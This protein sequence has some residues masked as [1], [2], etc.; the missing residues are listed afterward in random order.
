MGAACSTSSTAGGRVESTTHPSHQCQAHSHRSAQQLSSSSSP[1]P[2]SPLARLH[3]FLPSSPFPLLN[4]VVRLPRG[5]IRV[6]PALSHSS[7]PSNAV[8]ALPST[9]HPHLYVSVLTPSDSLCDLICRSPTTSFAFFLLAPQ[10]PAPLPSSPLTLQLHVA[11]H[12]LP[13]HHPD[14]CYATPFTSTRQMS[15]TW[16][17]SAATG[18]TVTLTP[19]SDAGRRGEAGD[20]AFP[21]HLYTARMSDKQY[22]RFERLTFTFL[23]RLRTFLLDATRHPAFTSVDAGHRHSMDCSPLHL[24]AFT[25]IQ[26]SGLRLTF[27]GLS[28]GPFHADIDWKGEQPR[29]LC[30]ELGPLIDAASADHSLSCFISRAWTTARGAIGLDDWRRLSLDIFSLSPPPPFLTSSIAAKGSTLR[31]AASPACCP[32]P[33]P[34][35]PSLA[36]SIGVDPSDPSSLMHSRDGSTRATFDRRFLRSYLREYAVQYAGTT[37]LDVVVTNLNPQTLLTPKRASTLAPPALASP[38]GKEESDERR[39]KQSVLEMLGKVM[40]AI[41]AILALEEEAPRVPQWAIDVTDALLHVLCL[42]STHHKLVHTGLAILRRFALHESCHQPLQRMLNQHLAHHPL[43]QGCLLALF[44]LLQSS[45]AFARSIQFSST[46]SRLLSIHSLASFTMLPESASLAPPPLPSLPALPPVDAH[47]PSHRSPSASHA[48]ATR[49]SSSPGS[50]SQPLQATSPPPLHPRQPRLSAMSFSARPPPS[51]LSSPLLLSPLR[52]RSSSAQP[53]S[54]AV[55]LPSLGSGVALAQTPTGAATMRSVSFLRSALSAAAHRDEDE[56]RQTSARVDMDAEL[57]AESAGSGSSSGV[58]S[59]LKASPGLQLR[60][61]S[62]P[63]ERKEADDADTTNSSSHTPTDSP[64]SASPLPTLRPHKSKHR[65]VHRSDYEEEEKVDH[66]SAVSSSP[67]VVIPKLKLSLAFIP[68]STASVVPAPLSSMR[69][70]RRMSRVATTRLGQMR[71]DAAFSYQGLMS[72]SATMTGFSIPAAMASPTSRVLG[73]HR[74]SILDPP[75]PSTFSL[76]SQGG[77]WLSTEAEGRAALRRLKDI[78]VSAGECFVTSQLA[79]LLWCHMQQQ[80]QQQHQQQQHDLATARL[81]VGGEEGGGWRRK[82]T[83]SLSSMAPQLTQRS[84]AEVSPSTAQGSATPSDLSLFYCAVLSLRCVLLLTTATST[85]RQSADAEGA[86]AS[87]FSALT[88]SRHLQRLKESGE[89]AGS[90]AVRLSF[91]HLRFYEQ[92]LCHA[93]RQCSSSPDPLRLSSTSPSLSSAPSSTSCLWWL[94]SRSGQSMPLLTTSGLTLA[95]S[96]PFAFGPTVCLLPTSLLSPINRASTAAYADIPMD[97]TTSSVSAP[98]LALHVT[99]EESSVAPPPIDGLVAARTADS[100]LRRRAAEL[101][102]VVEQLALLQPSTPYQHAVQLLQATTAALHSLHRYAIHSSCHQGLRSAFA[103]SSSHCLHPTLASSSSSDVSCECGNSIALLL[104]TCGPSLLDGHAQLSRI[105]RLCKEQAAAAAAQP[106][107]VWSPVARLPPVP[108]SSPP[109]EVER[110]TAVNALVSL[111]VSLLSHPSSHSTQSLLLRLLRDPTALPEGSSHQLPRWEKGEGEGKGPA[112]GARK[113]AQSDA[114]AALF[115]VLDFVHNH[116]L[117]VYASSASSYCL[118]VA[119]AATGG[120]RNVTVDAV[121]NSQRASLASTRMQRSSK[122]GSSG[123]MTGSGRDL[124]STAPSSAHSTAAAASAEEEEEVNAVPVP[125]YPVVHAARLYVL[126]FYRAVAWLL[127]RVGEST[128]EEL[129]D[130]RA[131]EEEL[132]PVGWPRPTIGDA[133]ARRS[134]RRAPI[135]EEEEEDDEDSDAPEPSHGDGNQRDD[136]EGANDLELTARERRQARRS[137]QARSRHSTMSGAP[138]ALGLSAEAKAERFE[139]YWSSV[140]ELIASPHALIARL[141]QLQ[142]TADGSRGGGDAG[143]EADSDSDGDDEEQTTEASTSRSSSSLSSMS[144]DADRSTPRRPSTRQA[145]Q[146][147]AEFDLLS[148]YSGLWGDLLGWKEAECPFL[149]DEKLMDSL[150]RLHFIAFIR[151]YHAQQGLDP[152]RADTCTLH[153]HILIAIST[154]TS[155]LLTSP[156]TAS[157]AVPLSRAR[158][159]SSRADLAG[160]EDPSDSAASPR[161]SE[162]PHRAVVDGICEAFHRLRVVHFLSKELN[163]EHDTFVARS[164]L[165]AAAGGGGPVTAGNTTA[166]NTTAVNTARGVGTVFSPQMSRSLSMLS[167]FDA[168][169]VPSSP[170]PALHQLTVAAA[171]DA[172]VTKRAEDVNSHPPSADPLPVTRVDAALQPAPASGEHRRS[173]SSPVSAP[174]PL[175]LPLNP[176]SFPSLDSSSGQLASPL[177]T[178][179]EEEDDDGESDEASPAAA[180][181]HSLTPKQG[182][183]REDEEDVEEDEAELSSAAEGSLASLQEETALRREHADGGDGDFDELTSEVTSAQ[184]SRLLATA[185]NRPSLTRPSTKSGRRRTF[186]SSDGAH[187]AQEGDTHG[188]EGVGDDDDEEL[189]EYEASDLS[190]SMKRPSPLDQLNLALP[191]SA[192]PAEEE[193][194][195][196]GADTAEHSHIGDDDDDGYEASETSSV[197]PSRAEGGDPPATQRPRFQLNIAPAQSVSAGT[198]GASPAEDADQEEEGDGDATEEESDLVNGWSDSESLHDA[199]TARRDGGAGLKLQLIVPSSSVSADPSPT[200]SSPS[201]SLAVKG[202]DGSVNASPAQLPS[203]RMPLRLP[204]SSDRTPELS[205]S[206]VPSNS[207]SSVESTLASLP[208]HRLPTLALKVEHSPEHAASPQSTDSSATAS[209]GA[210][211]P[212]LPAFSRVARH[213]PSLSLHLPAAAAARPPLSPSPLSTTQEVAI[214]DPTLPGV[215]DQPLHGDTPI[216]ATLPS[217][218]P[219]PL[220]AIGAVRGSFALAPPLKLQC[221]SSSSSSS[222]PTQQLSPGDEGRSVP[223]VSFSS[224]GSGPSSGRRSVRGKSFGVKVSS[225]VDVYAKLRQQRRLYN[226]PSLHAAMLRLL[227]RLL[228]DPSDSAL[229]S[230]YCDRALT[231]ANS[232]AD[233]DVDV[234]TSLHSHLNHPSNSTILSALFATSLTPHSSPLTRLLKLLCEPLFPT[235]LFLHP[236]STQIGRGQFAQVYLAHLPCLP[237]PLAVKQIDMASTAHQRVVLFDLFTEVSVMERMR[238]HKGVVGLV[239]YGV[240]RGQYYLVMKAMSKSLRAWREEVGKGKWGGGGAGQRGKR[241]ASREVVSPCFTE[242]QLMLYLYL[243][244]RVLHALRALHAAGV[245]HFDLKLDNV[246]IDL[247]SPSDPSSWSVAIADFGESLSVLHGGGSLISRGTENVQSPEMLLLT[248]VL[249]AGHHAFDRRR[250]HT[251]DAASDVWSLG[252]LFYEL[253]TN[254][255]LFEASDGLPIVLR[256]TSQ[257]GS[258]L[259][260]KERGMLGTWGGRPNRALMK[261]LCGVLVHNKDR[262]PTL[263]K[264]EGMFEAMVKELFPRGL[265]VTGRGEGLMSPVL[266]GPVGVGRQWMDGAHKREKHQPRSLSVQIDMQS[267]APPPFLPLASSK[268]GVVDRL[269]GGG[270]GAEAAAASPRAASALAKPMKMGRLLSSRRLSILPS[271]PPLALHYTPVSEDLQL[272]IHA[273]LSSLCVG[274]RHGKAT[275]VTPAD[276]FSTSPWPC[277]HF[278]QVRIAKPGAG[279]SRPDVTALSIPSLTFHGWHREGGQAPTAGSLPS[280]APSWSDEPLLLSSAPQEV[281]EVVE[282]MRDAIALG[283]RALLFVDADEVGV[284]ADDQL[285]SLRGLCCAYVMAVYGVPWLEAACMVHEKLPISAP[286]VDGATRL[287]SALSSASEPERPSVGAAPAARHHRESLF[288][289]SVIVQQATAADGR[290]RSTGLVVS[291][292]SAPFAY[293]S[294]WPLRVAPALLKWMAASTLHVNP[295][296]PLSYKRF[297]ASLSSASPSPTALVTHRCLCGFCLLTCSIASPIRRCRC[298]PSLSTSPLPSSPFTQ[299]PTAPLGCRWFEARTK[300]LYGRGGALQWKALQPPSP[301][302]APTPAFPASSRSTA[303]TSPPTPSQWSPAVPFAVLTALRSVPYLSHSSSSGWHLYECKH[304]L[305]PFL[306]VLPSTPSS[307]SAS[308]SH[309]PAAG[310]VRCDGLEVMGLQV[311][312]GM[313]VGRDDRVQG[314]SSSLDDDAHYQLDRRPR[315]FFS[316]IA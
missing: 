270:S 100:W 96:R 24:S 291:K 138:V 73:T 83:V 222:S 128:R 311:L 181:P 34:P 217:F 56:K 103:T 81:G 32:S 174:Q 272:P 66:A 12:Y 136:E 225:A 164:Y 312:A 156:L 84:M 211:L 62:A 75:A 206:V 121:F 254:R 252:C 304:C 127:Q 207:S 278:I 119:T 240:S 51:T 243:F 125:Q 192:A 25:D 245:V 237:Q 236:S 67:A 280:T 134:S 142:V 120:P 175:M 241:W 33:H 16:V 160:E 133:T 249:D 180:S 132:D 155:T 267:S 68:Q 115:S 307:S 255:F 140:G 28:H 310:C 151:N 77:Q 315:A 208:S 300:N 301:T 198:S 171:V 7:N 90:A 124:Y 131:S 275:A 287:T 186:D 259:S 309:D 45:P 122:A 248:Q 43:C 185:S 173:A 98:A 242:S 61:T 13:R 149:L 306:A 112:R 258:L 21:A 279:I 110:L 2:R 70:S 17:H 313:R 210:A 57:T 79:T 316:R 261:F 197:R 97:S 53:A 20:G 14:A 126:D 6:D 268:L 144:S 123:A 35:V 233:S 87:A 76:T 276:Y 260:E 282:A 200:A 239:E 289:P 72:P 292:L 169:P 22:Q 247:P 40:E 163:A 108:S 264:V 4:G 253:L 179:P 152:L 188:D 27:P 158:R 11:Y 3:S 176:N 118:F 143:D 209:G 93:I 262:R 244:R 39:M 161:G 246:L 224:L 135:A 23:P 150:A 271:A 227:L 221:S 141:I 228:V 168:Q 46:L 50:A 212:S 296:L 18:L 42:H 166:V 107:P 303:S 147:L 201:L 298:Q 202:A 10:Q 159:G 177:A 1:Y 80:Q 26:R 250:N 162:H 106:Q 220:S 101:A 229:S 36:R 283:G 167:G 204:L 105:Y 78:A 139:W 38:R 41:H 299:C 170:F 286:P 235:S 109:L 95:F 49:R 263:A 92:L 30:K 266:G 102:A 256:V 154:A 86:L 74:F 5:L 59:I 205:V 215:P 193:H 60:Q 157:S 284:V 165:T 214:P 111:W 302:G 257:S 137:R 99:D 238:G 216:L 189:D 37:M 265:H 199:S 89:G 48:S 232:K 145:R 29:L 251:V 288:R 277:T 178:H 190:V 172:P 91:T 31:G 213:Q 63:E 44:H 285:D 65:I 148:A 182:E 184:H 223:G 55:G 8:V 290:T 273:V 146:R 294:L 314:D 94:R 194:N 113:R 129:E 191:A 183:G 19:S 52:Q 88:R 47:L 226:Q 305:H 114:T 130:A 274:A 9:L 82:E 281:D 297:A 187:R 308:L 85:E 153:L 230:L 15:T 195:G 295:E 69:H 116:A 293:A 219:P 231:A 203:L 234:L 104:H 64:A 196:E 218:V 269:S 71:A 54:A 58:R 117:L